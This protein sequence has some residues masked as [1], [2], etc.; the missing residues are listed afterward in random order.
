[1]TLGKQV[2][3]V[4][5]N[6][7]GSHR[8]YCL[9]QAVELQQQAVAKVYGAYACRV[10]AANGIEYVAYVTVV[11]IEAFG[12]GDVVAYFA[13]GACEVSVIVKVADDMCRDAHVGIVEVALGGKA[14]HQYLAH[15]FFVVGSVTGHFNV[16]VV[17]AA[18]VAQICRCVVGI[19]IVG[20]L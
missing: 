15:A 10:E 6:L 2:E 19:G 4:G 7:A 18:V 14:A 17:A 20:H 16:A 12:N 1:M 11:N 5:D 9:W 8:F 13:Q 3:M